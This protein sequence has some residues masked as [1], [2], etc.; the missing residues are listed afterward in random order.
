MAAYLQLRE[1]EKQAEMEILQSQSQPKNLQSQPNQA[2]PLEPK[3][4][5][6][7]GKTKMDRVHT[8]GEKPEIRLSENGK[9]I[10][11]DDDHL[12]SEF[13]NFLG[14]VA[15]ERMQK[16]KPDEPP[17]PISDTDIY[18]KTR[19]RDE[20]REY[21]LPTEMWLQRRFVQDGYASGADNDTP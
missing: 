12:L 7:R 10:S 20:T 16:A 4:R 9:P 18:V 3:K 8:R 17:T 14:T 6:G 2:A 21:K 13:S 5:K 1:Q 11:D 15:I 19:K